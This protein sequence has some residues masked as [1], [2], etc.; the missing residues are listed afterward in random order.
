[1]TYKRKDL[2]ILDIENKSLVIAC[3][4]CGGIG[5]KENDFFKVDPYYVGSLTTRVVLFEVLSTGAK[6]VS[7]SNAVCNEMNETAK[8]ILVGVKAELKKACLEEVAITGSTEEN[9]PTSMT[10]VGMTCIGIADKSS[11]RFSKGEVGDSLV[12][13]G[14][15]KVGPELN[16]VYDEQVAKYNDIFELLNFEGLVEMSATGSKGILHECNILADLNG[17][18]VDVF[19]D[20]DIDLKKSCGVSTCLV[21]LVKKEWLDKLPTSMTPIKVIGRLS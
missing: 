2:S 8:K 12:L 5:E 14:V 4:S 17:C 13:Y 3:D 6:V 11:L 15:P 19:D 20:L 16:L 18:K 1:M 9:M 21:A 10:A 7:L